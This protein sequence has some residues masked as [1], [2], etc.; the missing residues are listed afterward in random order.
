MVMDTAPL[1]YFDRELRITSVR[2]L[3]GQ[4]YATQ[5]DGSIST[6][7]GSCVATCLWDP[8][9][10]IGGM[11][12]FMLPGEAAAP[13]SPWALS[14]RFGINAMELL[15]N[16]MVHLGADRRRFVAKVFGGARV[17]QGFERFDVGA[18]NSEFVLSFLRE[19]GIELLGQDLL[20]ECPRKVHFFPATGKVQLK[21]LSLRQDDPV[22]RQEQAYL[23]GLS[24]QSGSGDV[25]IF[26]R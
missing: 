24:G 18:R 11:N 15:I 16:T 10:R 22:Q 5:G 20:G 13:T 21:R 6:V 14:A 9:R 17:L 7:L 8:V 3:P 1:G 25:E 12:H 19:E 26:S 2:V 23:Q 4:Y